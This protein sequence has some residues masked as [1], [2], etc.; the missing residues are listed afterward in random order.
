MQLGIILAGFWDADFRH[1]LLM[2]SAVTV[3][4]TMTIVRISTPTTTTTTE[5]IIIREL[6][7]C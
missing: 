7:D 2:I 3:T 6:D 5:M 1:F 4:V